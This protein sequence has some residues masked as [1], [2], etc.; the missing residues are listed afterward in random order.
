[1][2]SIE[3][4]LAILGFTEGTITLVDIKTAY[5]VKAKLLHPDKGGD[6]KKFK[7]LVAAYELLIGKARIR[8]KPQPVQQQQPWGAW[9]VYVEYGSWRTS[10]STTGSTYA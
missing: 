6:A 4:A 7:E 5:R 2:L 3:Q 9:K 1:M 8:L 10:A